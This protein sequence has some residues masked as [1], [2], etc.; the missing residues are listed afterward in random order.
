MS[1]P[2]AWVPVCRRARWAW[3]VSQLMD[4]WSLLVKKGHIHRVTSTSK[5]S[6]F[7][8]PK[9]L[10]NL[11]VIPLVLTFS[12]C[13]LQLVF[14]KTQTSYSDTQKLKKIYAEII[15]EAIFCLPET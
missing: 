9:P 6:T 3:G 2:P 14:F 7:G 12:S 10:S 4:A 13:C 11:L 15:F 1:V 5:S 8:M